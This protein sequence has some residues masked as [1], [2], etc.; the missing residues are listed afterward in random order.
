[1][2]NGVKTKVKPKN[3]KMTDIIISK[4]SKVVFWNDL[5]DLVHRPDRCHITIMTLNNLIIDIQY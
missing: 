2:T 4:N 3:Q 1:V 5:V